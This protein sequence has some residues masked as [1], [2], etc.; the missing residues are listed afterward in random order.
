MLSHILENEM[1]NETSDNPDEVKRDK[2]QLHHYLDS[3]LTFPYVCRL[4]AH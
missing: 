1:A 4:S 2:I 3:H